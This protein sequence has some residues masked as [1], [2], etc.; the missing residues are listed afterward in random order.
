MKFVAQ[1][2]RGIKQPYFSS[3]AW[4]LKMVILQKIFW[5][6]ILPEPKTNWKKVCAFGCQS[7][8][9]KSVFLQKQLIYDFYKKCHKVWVIVKIWGAFINWSNLVE[10]IN[11]FFFNFQ[12]ISMVTLLLSPARL[13]CIWYW[14]TIWYPLVTN[15]HCIDNIG[16]F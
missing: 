9:C 5:P 10:D 15:S 6:F 3:R 1:I 8:F 13:I 16:S 12:I 4:E 14:V 11:N 7:C 2:S